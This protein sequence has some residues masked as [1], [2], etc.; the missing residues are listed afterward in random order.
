MVGKKM[1]T[2][3][4]EL[5]IKNQQVAFEERLKEVEHGL[6]T[7]ENMTK[8]LSATVNGLRQQMEIDNIPEEAEDDYI[9]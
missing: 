5:M 8:G 7:L 3:I 2:E 6:K 1:I 4:D 9:R